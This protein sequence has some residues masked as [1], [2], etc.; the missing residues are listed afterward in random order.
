MKS[1][2]LELAL[3]NETGD[4]QM[5]DLI[6]YIK[7]QWDD[8]H[9]SRNQDWKVLALII[10]I[11][12]AL[13][14]LGPSHSWLYVPI[15]ILGIIACIMGIYMSLMHWLIFYSKSRVISSCEKILGIEPNLY[16][17]PFPVQGLILMLYFFICGILGGLLVWVWAK[18]IWVSYV[19]FIMCF[20]LGFFICLVVNKRIHAIVGKQTPLVNKN[21]GEK[22]E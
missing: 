18:K 13:L 3:L 20:F 7:I 17:T 4:I 15:A 12:Y 19:I 8:I 9:H 21:L 22:N 5:S 14:N 16:K 11:F 2:V 10:G 1:T 6:D